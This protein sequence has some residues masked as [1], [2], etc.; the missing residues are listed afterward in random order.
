MFTSPGNSRAPLHAVPL[1]EPQGSQAWHVGA[2]LTARSWHAG[3]TKGMQGPGRQ[4]HTHPAGGM[5]QPGACSGWAAAPAQTPCRAYSAVTLA[6]QG[7]TAIQSAPLLALPTR[8]RPRLIPQNRLQGLSARTG[9]C[10][11]RLLRLPHSMSPFAHA[12]AAYQLGPEHP[13]QYDSMDPWPRREHDLAVCADLCSCHAGR[14]EA[15]WHPTSL[16]DKKRWRAFRCTAWWRLGTW[17]YPEQ[18]H[19]CCS[20]CQCSDPAAAQIQR[21]TFSCRRHQ[22]P[23]R[24]TVG[25]NLRAATHPE[26]RCC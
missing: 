11:M 20:H 7:R 6:L 14:C 16:L 13:P 19:C 15:L 4:G 26:Q 12:A 25:V 1:C 5:S 18:R 8:L 3:F 23:C 10:I 2:S 24:S 9:I 21:P 22:R 17:V